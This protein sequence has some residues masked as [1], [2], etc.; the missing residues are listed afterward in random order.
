M[1]KKLLSR[2]KFVLGSAALIPVVAC[3]PSGGGLLMAGKPSSSSAKSPQWLVTNTSLGITV[4]NANGKTA[5]YFS[6]GASPNTVTC[7]TTLGAVALPM[8]PNLNGL[9][10]SRFATSLQLSQNTLK[11]SDASGWTSFSVS[12]NGTVTFSDSRCG[13]LVSSLGRPLSS[14]PTSAKSPSDCLLN[15]TRMDDGDCGDGDGLDET[16]TSGDVDSIAIG[17]DD[18]EDIGIM[19]MAQ[20]TNSTQCFLATLAALGGVVVSGSR[21]YGIMQ[22]IAEAAAIGET[23]PG[24]NVLELAGL[25][26]V[27]LAAVLYAMYEC[28]M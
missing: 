2:G 12:T 26:T 11:S 1:S 7:N 28:G 18:G 15:A 4:Q 23:I 9:M 5:A 3:S 22:A 17:I 19:T 14:A 13:T 25:I 16:L 8:F 6:S 27:G 20:A 10:A 24:V 21:A